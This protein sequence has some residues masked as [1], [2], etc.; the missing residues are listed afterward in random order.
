MRTYTFPQLTAVT[1]GAALATGITHQVYASICSRSFKHSAFEEHRVTCGTGNILTYYKREG[2]PGGPTVVFAAGLMST[3]VSWLLIADHLDPAISVVVYD[4]A[5]Y[6]KSL[7][8]C[9]EVYSLGE[10]VDDL[11]DV[12]AA[13][14][15]DGPVFL[16]GHS[17][18][19][20]MAYRMVSTPPRA[21][22]GTEPT[23]T[24]NGVILV[25]PSHPNELLR[26]KRQR[27]GSSNADMSLKL[28]PTSTLLGTGL[29]A[30]T[31]GLLDFANGSPYQKQL[32]MES[33]T[34]STWRAAKREWRHT[35][36]HMLDGVDHLQQVSVPVSVIA[37]GE[38]L[39][40]EKVQR[41]LYDEFVSLGTGGEIVDI[42]GA[43]HLSLIGGVE[44][45]PLTAAAVERFVTTWSEQAA[46]SGTARKQKSVKGKTSKAEAK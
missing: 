15:G 27:V 10:S 45:A 35:Y 5:G 11:R 36:A 19:G 39:S 31:Q 22:E 28:G 44:Y 25:D 8:R 43:T 14:A 37:A 38:T 40:T 18:G 42:E 34:A 17:L 29:L 20:Y 24:I 7:R 32:R 12:V 30:D 21:S 23:P 3:S 13:S 26:S 46:D 6:R 9:A 33:S 41:D 1:L 16:A 2:R 4:R